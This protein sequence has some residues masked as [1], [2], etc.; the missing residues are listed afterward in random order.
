MAL[1][2]SDLSDT[3]EIAFAA[4][5]LAHEGTHLLDDVGKVT[6]GWVAAATERIIAAGGDGT[7][8]GQAV[9]AQVEFELMM[10]NEARAFTFAGQV[11]RDLGVQLAAADPT[12]VA[13]AGRNDAA[14]YAQVWQALLGTSS[15][16]PERRS[17]A[18]T[19]L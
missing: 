6:Q 17:A 5:A 18:V 14:T 13:A 10:I 16:N 12:S 1:R 15:Y 8:G 4:V 2:R 7:A 19:M 3:Q 11:A 9:M